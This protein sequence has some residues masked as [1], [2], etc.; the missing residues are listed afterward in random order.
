MAEQIGTYTLLFQSLPSVL[1]SCKSSRL[2][3][4]SKHIAFAASHDRQSETQ[5]ASRHLGTWEKKVEKVLT[6]SGYMP[7]IREWIQNEP[8]C[9]ITLDF[10]APFPFLQHHPQLW[11]PFTMQNNHV[12]YSQSSAHEHISLD[13]F[14]HE[15]INGMG[16][17][18]WPGF[19]LFSFWWT[20]VLLYCRAVW[21]LVY[22]GMRLKKYVT[23]NIWIPG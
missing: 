23:S 9:S 14:P 16:R 20:D 13:L 12:N 10:Q 17:E 5:R 18:N 6:R 19:F 22:G 1:M 4:V 2:I 3:S 15:K 7:V 8:T 11:C 21:N